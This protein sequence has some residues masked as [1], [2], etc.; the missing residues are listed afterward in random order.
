MEYSGVDGDSILVVVMTIIA[1][2]K[3]FL[4]TVLWD[5]RF[6]KKLS[7]LTLSYS[8]YIGSL[9]T[10]LFSIGN[11]IKIDYK[12]T[13]KFSAILFYFDHLFLSSV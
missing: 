3:N 12:D 6:L 9:T 10:I 13:A 8:F 4:R 2:E 1:V 11:E 7:T 5:R